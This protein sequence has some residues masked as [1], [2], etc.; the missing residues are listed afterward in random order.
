MLRREIPNGDPGAIFERALALLAKDVEKTKLG[1]PRKQRSP[2]PEAG[3]REGAYEKRIRF[4]TYLD[5]SVK[6]EVRPALGPLKEDGLQTYLR[7]HP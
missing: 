7:P 4:E 1:L 5:P 2:R 3:R 6:R